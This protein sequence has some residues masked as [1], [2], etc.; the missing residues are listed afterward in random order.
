MFCASK[1]VILDDDV[2]RIEELALADAGWK[3]Y[4]V[5]PYND[6]EWIRKTWINRVLAI[7]QDNA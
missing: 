2:D 6:L 3:S 7:L 4:R 1:V 5:V